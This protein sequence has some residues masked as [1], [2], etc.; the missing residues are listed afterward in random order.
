MKK[1][2][3]FSV[4]LIA[5]SGIVGDAFG[6]RFES[7]RGKTGRSGSANEYIQLI[8]SLYLECD[9]DEGDVG[10]G[11]YVMFNYHGNDTVYSKRCDIE[12]DGDLFRDV[13][14]NWCNDKNK[15]GTGEQAYKTGDRRV[16]VNMSGNQV[17]EIGGV[18]LSQNKHG[19]VICGDG[20]MYDD[21]S[22]S[23]RTPTKSSAQ[24]DCETAKQDWVNG[25]CLCKDRK[26]EWS[27]T[28]KAC[29]GTGLVVTK[30]CDYKGKKI[31]P[32][33]TEDCSEKMV[34]RENFVSATMI[35]LDTGKWG[36]CNVKCSN[37]AKPQTGSDSKIKCVVENVTPVE[38]I[39]PA[40]PDVYKCDQET[41]AWVRY[42][43]GHYGD[44]PEIVKLAQDIINFCLDKPDKSGFDV[45]ISRLKALIAEHENQLR[46]QQERERQITLRIKTVTDISGELKK[47]A[48]NDL[49]VWRD[50]EGNF[51]TS[52]LISDSVAG[53]V[54]GTAGGLITSN[55]IKKNQVEN[56]FEDISC[57]VGGQ[58]VAGWGDEFRVGIR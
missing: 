36:D 14:I 25:E 4:F 6:G 33:T 28:A 16:C 37:N 32:G 57:T 47:T 26:L 38:P 1:L 44:I 7:I 29:K 49:T 9:D 54:L 8:N 10:D 15:C 23:C 30:T 19:C 46:I 45:Y 24:I 52:R 55:V 20:T 43:I 58:V 41:L 50:A 56:G 5:L 53:V 42:V 34:N 17:K 22:K 35:C 3:L 40:V 51:N 27:P 2:A 11:V 21:N 18:V 48:L 13:I 12:S 31:N 39:V